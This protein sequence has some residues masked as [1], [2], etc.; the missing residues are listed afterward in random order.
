MEESINHRYT[1]VFRSWVFWLCVITGIAIFIRSVPAWINTAWGCDFGIY[2]GLTNSFVEHKELFSVYTG[3]GGSYQYFPVLYVITG[4]AHWATGLDVLTVMPKLA[5]IFG[6]LTVLIFYFIVYTLFDDHKKALLA[7]AFLA[8][9]PFHVYQTS[10]AAPLTIGHFFMMLSLYFFIRF[11]RD[12]R[13]F[14]P[15]LFSTVLLTMSHH[16]TTYFYVISLVFIV[17]VENASQHT[18]TNTLKN[19]I[20]YILVASGIVFSYWAF[21]ATPVF[22][23]FLAAGLKVGSIFLDS[24]FVLIM[25][26]VLFF[27]MF[28]VIWLK[29]RYNLFRHPKY[30]T[31]TSSLIKFGFSIAICLTAMTIFSVMKMPWTN[32]SFTPLSFAYALPLVVVIGFG[33]AGFRFT[34]FIPNGYVIRGWILALLVSFV[35]VLITK[36]SIMPPDR[37]LEYIMVPLS[38][39]AV[40]GIQGILCAPRFDFFSRW[41]NAVQKI[42]WPPVLRPRK[43]WFLKKPQFLYIFVVIVLLATNAVSVYPGFTSLNVAYEVIT[44][45]NI[46][47]IRWMDLNLDKNTSVIASDHRLARMA[48]AVGFNT[49]VNEASQI[50][51]T[52]NLTDYLDELSG[53]GK[54]YTYITHVFVDNIM[55]ERVVHVYFGEIFYMTNDS[56]EKF[57]YPPFELLYRNVSFDENGFEQR[58]AEV[59]AVNWTYIHSIVEHVR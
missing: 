38:V 12:R 24:F 54:N 39:I 15:L 13:F 32:F 6:G 29:R 53:K 7:S 22:D 10:H 44:D 23:N 26:Y 37:H 5:P 59:Y 57:L 20:A 17:F 8:V 40:F 49:T 47:T 2:Y 34:R 16:L 19:D 52:E 31:R 18:W 50:W 33:V 1:L 41:K 21:V 28:G 55:R 4:F 35:Y 46:A 36:N 30:P 45:E 3:W 27:L 9:L 11:R 42:N 56:Y 43:K 25:F 51:I 58:W 14:I 48:E